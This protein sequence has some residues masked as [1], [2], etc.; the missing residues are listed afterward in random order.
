MLP[1]S[2]EAGGVV[3]GMADV[4]PSERGGARRVD[5]HATSS[6]VGPRRPKRSVGLL[7]ALVVV[8]GCGWFAWNKIA[9]PYV[10]P[11]MRPWLEQGHGV[12]YS[13][14]ASGWSVSLPAKPMVRTVRTV[15]GRG[16]TTYASIAEAPA[17][18]H[19][20]GVVSFVALPSDLAIDPDG[21]AAAAADAAAL[22][23]GYR[24]DVPESTSDHGAPALSAE[25]T[26][27]Q[28][29]TGDAYT[30]VKGDL[31]VTVFVA[32]TDHGGSG[33]DHLRHSLKFS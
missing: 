30:V 1:A 2:F 19:D 4:R 15:V 25:I 3:P 17:G 18:G 26:M 6:P 29:A 22:A 33:F 28:G 16:T 23:V 11:E 21:P 32:G 20:I 9:H 12:T 24:I 13:P 8:A 14:A 10:P 7:L 31:V 27:E 5:L